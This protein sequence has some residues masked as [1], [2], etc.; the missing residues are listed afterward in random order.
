[1]PVSGKKDDDHSKKSSLEKRQANGFGQPGVAG[2]P[3]LDATSLWE[4]RAQERMTELVDKSLDAI[5]R[6]ISSTSSKLASDVALKFMRQTWVQDQKITVENTGN[7]Q[8][9]NYLVLQQDPLTDKEKLA[10][11]RLQS[12]L[13]EGNDRDDEDVIEVE[14]IEDPKNKS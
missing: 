1:M 9:N 2:R 3:R 12:I 6:A 4:E 10:M 14:A 13:K 11:N 5:E 7:S 8:T